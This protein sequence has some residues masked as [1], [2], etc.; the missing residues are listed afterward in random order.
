M[1]DDQLVCVRVTDAPALG[2]TKMYQVKISC[3]GKTRSLYK[4]KDDFKNVV[5]MFKLVGAMAARKTEGRCEICSTCSAFPAVKTC[6]GEGFHDYLWAVLD[7]LRKA[8]LEAVDECSTHKG[9]MQILMDFL[10]ISKCKYFC[11]LQDADPT[12]ESEEEQENDLDHPIAQC[13]LHRSIS[14]HFSA[15]DSVC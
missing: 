6:D 12:V 5:N 1:K 11:E 8:P 4:T 2:G 14:E 9:V 15:F 7:K 13:S 10:S 3:K